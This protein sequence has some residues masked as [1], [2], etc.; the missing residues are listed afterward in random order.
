MNKEKITELALG[1][2]VSSI[3]SWNECELSPAEILKAWQDGKEADGVE[4][5]EAFQDYDPEYLAEECESL[6]NQ[7]VSFAEWV[8]EEASK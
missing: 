7:F 2:A 4:I 8:L 1:E 5:S 6:R 3:I